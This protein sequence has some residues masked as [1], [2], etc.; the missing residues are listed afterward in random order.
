MPRGVRVMNPY[1]EPRVKTAVRAFFGKYYADNQKRVLVVGINPGRF[2]GGI[3]G[4]SFTDPVALAEA[5]GIATD[6]PQVRELSSRFV[7]DFVA[8]YGGAQRFFGRFFL[9]AASP[10]GFTRDGVNLNYYDEPVLAR[11]MEPFIVDTIERQIAMGG[12]TDAAI[13][14]G[15]GANLKVLERLNAEHGFFDR[16]IPLEHPRWIMQYRR[17][18]VARYLDTYKAAFDAAYN[19]G[20]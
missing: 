16:L 20:E 15:R 6:L 8:H 17:R 2:G 18:S 19:G 5:C 12:R 14:L 7:Y 13:V 10:L 11:R 4:I 3:T 1:H 9:T